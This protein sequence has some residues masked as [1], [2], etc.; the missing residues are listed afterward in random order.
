M[1]YFGLFFYILDV[2]GIGGLETVPTLRVLMLGRNRIQRIENL[3]PVRHLDV[4]DLHGNCIQEI[5]GLSTLQVYH[6]DNSPVPCLSTQPYLPSLSCSYVCVRTLHARNRNGI[7]SPLLR[8]CA[9]SILPA[10]PSPGWYPCGTN[11]AIGPTTPPLQ[12]PLH[13]LT[14]R[15]DPAAWM[16]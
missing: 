4:L 9:C 16:L 12:P 3:E 2:R 15:S 10:M 11:P 14:I 7:T 5:S 6:D 8:S 13:F 1:I